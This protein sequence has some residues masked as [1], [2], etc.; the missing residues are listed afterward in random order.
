[1]KRA[2]F[3]A[4]IL[5]ALTTLLLAAAPRPA[6]AQDT[7]PPADA[8]DMLAIPEQGGLV[9][10]PA[11]ITP[12]PGVPDSAPPPV[13]ENQSAMPAPQ[14]AQGL[15]PTQGIILEDGPDTAPQKTDAMALLAQLPPDIQEEIMREANFSFNFCRQDVMMGS[16]YD[17][18]CVALDIIER[19][20]KAGPGVPFIN[21]TNERDFE[22]CAS[23]PLIAGYAHDRCMDLYAVVKMGERLSTET[24]ACASRIM[25]RNFKRRPRLNIFYVDDMFNNIIVSCQSDARRGVTR[26]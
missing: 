6:G 20:I 23:E 3:S 17:C 11:V 25:T 18:S 9:P 10:G 8:G 16:F 26:P 12:T 14:G 5:P 13:T 19:R 7:L 1:M 15:P 21:V 22:A 2:L 4:L 24:C